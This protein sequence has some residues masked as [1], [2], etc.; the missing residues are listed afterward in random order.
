[1]LAI[2]LA[3]AIGIL[4]GGGAVALVFRT[5]RPEQSDVPDPT[6]PGGRALTPD[7]EIALALR[8][9]VDHLEIGFIGTLQLSIGNVITLGNR[10]QGP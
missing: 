9:A 1:M 2:V 7:D 3:S 4:V 6:P 5:R 8:E 10:L